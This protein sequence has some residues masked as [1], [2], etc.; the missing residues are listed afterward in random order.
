MSN[1]HYVVKVGHEDKERLSIQHQTFSA[2]TEDFLLRINLQPG[3]K[4]L[5]V[6]CGAGDETVL[7]ANIVGS[8]G[9]VTAIDVSEEQVK[10]AQERINLENLHHVN[11][12]VLA[13]EELD[14]LSDQF[15]IVFCRMVLV[16]IADPINALKKM[17]SKVKI[18]CILACEEPDISTCFTMP[19]SPSF[20]KHIDLLCKFLMA[21]GC[22][23]DYGTKTYGIFKKLGLS[24]VKINFSQPAVTDSQQKTA[25]LLSA[26][27]CGPQYITANLASKEE[28][29]SMISNI[30]TEVVKNDN[31]IMGQCRMAQVYGIRVK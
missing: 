25:A 2:G 15:D 22:D 19:N 7:I 26:K 21:K 9:H 29:E 18:N 14:K 8:K 11:I 27:N 4:V 12:K 17:I 13:A 10:V 6:G 24:G 16:H 28:V 20:D 1:S 23:P 3:Q 31:L 30:E 5:V